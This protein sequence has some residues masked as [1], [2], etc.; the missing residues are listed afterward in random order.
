MWVFIV[1]GA[2]QNRQRVAGKGQRA[3]C[4]KAGEEGDSVQTL[5]GRA[6]QA[7]TQFSRNKNASLEVKQDHLL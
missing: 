4:G 1:C 3:R 6:E 2:V 5:T 7:F